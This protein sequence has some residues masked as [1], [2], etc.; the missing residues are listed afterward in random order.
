MNGIERLKGRKKMQV[1]A[2]TGHGN[3][4]FNPFINK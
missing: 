4:F 2:R 1:K 3:T